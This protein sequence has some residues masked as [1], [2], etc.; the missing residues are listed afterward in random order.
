LLAL[1]G[2]GFRGTFDERG[3]KAELAAE[4]GFAGRHLSLVSLM[5][6]AVEMQKAVEDED[7]KLV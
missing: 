3:G 4:F 1:R 6:H 7:A 5:V 2:R